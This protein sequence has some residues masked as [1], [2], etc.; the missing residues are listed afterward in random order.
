MSAYLLVRSEVEISSREGFDNWYQNEH[1][2]SSLKE[3]K[4][5]IG[6]WRAWSDVEDGIHFAFY[7]FENLESAHKLLNSDIMKE[8]I[9]EFDKHWLGKVTRSRDVFEVKQ[10]LKK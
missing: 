8:F 3:F 2:P 6:A 10:S 7:K 5:S 9:K 1:L 4:D